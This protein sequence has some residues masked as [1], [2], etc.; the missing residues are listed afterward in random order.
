MN[1][2]LPKNGV[3][4]IV[5]HGIICQNAKLGI[6]FWQNCQHSTCP[7]VTLV[8]SDPDASTLLDSTSTTPTSLTIVDEEEQEC[9]FHTLIWVH[10]NPLHL[11][12]DNG[13]HNKFVSEDLVK[14]LGL[15]T[16]PH[17]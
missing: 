15:V 12:V 16:T 14:I 8:E 11:I 1:R 2:T 9:L 5:H 13:I 4:I 3:I 17:P 6:I 7:T 10:K